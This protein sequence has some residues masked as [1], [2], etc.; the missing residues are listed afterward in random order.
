MTKKIIILTIAAIFLTTGAGFSQMRGG[1]DKDGLKMPRGKWWKIP[2]VKEELKITDAEQ[3]KM[4]RLFID[5]RRKMIDLKAN[6]EREKLDLEVLLDNENF[7]KNDCMKQYQELQ[8]A[9]DMLGKEKFSFI[10]ETRE[11]FGQ[12]RFALLASKR[13]AFMKR[14]MNKPDEKRSK[15]GGKKNRY[16]NQQN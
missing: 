1:G 7:S 12:E 9:K 3:K 10:L 8:A 13:K 11:L 2:T 16:M 6:V 15:S 14:N 4:D 5:S